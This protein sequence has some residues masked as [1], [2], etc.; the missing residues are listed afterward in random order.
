MYPDVSTVYQ[1]MYIYSAKNHSTSYMYMYICTVPSM[2][3]PAAWYCASCYGLCQLQLYQR[4][5]ATGTLPA[6]TKHLPV[7]VHMYRYI[8]T[9]SFDKSSFDKSSFDKTVPA[10][11]QRMSATVQRM[12]ANVSECQLLSSECQRM[13]ANKAVSKYFWNMYQ[14]MSAAVHVLR[15]VLSS[16]YQMRALHEFTNVSGS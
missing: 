2:P 10:A 9:C 5:S 15:Y 14:L 6:S 11:D 1:Y 7:H 13:S 16:G 3:V 8:C 4:M 12:S